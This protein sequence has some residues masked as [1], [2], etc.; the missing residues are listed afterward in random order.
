[1]SRNGHS[2]YFN[3][4]GGH[5]SRAVLILGQIKANLGKEFSKLLCHLSVVVPNHVRVAHGCSWV[6]VTQP[7]LSHL[8]RCVQVIE[9]T[10]VSVPERMCCSIE[11][12]LLQDRLQLSL[13]E[14]VRV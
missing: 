14:V 6:G 1:M 3:G 8:H 4:L 10:C 13:D 12:K 5:N 7:I 11:S 2:C 9:Q